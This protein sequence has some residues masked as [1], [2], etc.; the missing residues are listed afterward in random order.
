M[1]ILVIN[2][3]SST[4]KYQIIDMENETVIAKGNCER[5]NLNDGFVEYKHNGKEYKFT[6]IVG[7]EQALNKVLEVLTDEK[8]GAIKSM[9]E[10]TAVAHRVVQGGSVFNQS[11]LIDK[12]VIKEIEKLSSLA[13]LHNPANLIGIRA[14][15]KI[16]K[17]VPNVAVFDTAFHQ[18]MPAYAY[19]YPIDKKDIK[20]FGIRRYGAHGTSHKYVAEV[21]A[22]LLGKSLDKCNIITCHMGGGCS[23]T[24]IAQGKSVDTSMGFT[25]LDGVIMGTRSGGI[26]P[27]IVDYLSVKKGMTSAEVISYL[28][29]NCGILGVS[30]ISSDLRT[31]NEAIKKGNEDAKLAL[32]ILKYQ[33]K[34]YIGS[35]MAVLGHVDAIVFTGGVGENQG[36][37]REYACSNLENFGIKFDAKKNASIPRGTIET[38]S[39]RGSKVKVFR[40]PTDEELAMARDCVRIIEN[41]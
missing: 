38:L 18:T 16:M 39:K 8:I 13:P 34:K 5:L 10:I 2:A 25:P 20:K 19:T 3:G 12:K 31:I 23:I 17:N 40:I 35:Y 33:T 26:D 14:C 7:H 41:M 27:S 6:G 15:M 4:L 22:K 32:D 21:A 1:K 9:D 24:A 29:K 36:D 37:L 11:V 28:N 30:G